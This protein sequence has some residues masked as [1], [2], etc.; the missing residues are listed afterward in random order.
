MDRD[1]RLQAES[2]LARISRDEWNDLFSDTE[3]GADLYLR[4]EAVR[5]ALGGAG[6]LPLGAKR[7]PVQELLDLRGDQLLNNDDLGPWIR[8]RLLRTMPETKWA[9]LVE[10][11]VEHS[12]SRA[13]RFHRNMVQHR[14]GPR[15][16]AG[17]WHH[18]GRWAQ[19]FCD[20]TG[21]PIDLAKRRTGSL[22]EDEDIL[23]AEPL[24]PLHDFQVE[25]YRSMRRLLRG[26][27]GSAAMLSLPTGA[28]KTRVAVEAICDHLAQENVGSRNVV[29]WI[30]MSNELQQQA[31]EC[32]RQVWQVP[33]H[34]D[35][36]GIRRPL[37][38]RLVRLWGG[39]SGDDIE[40][41]EQ[42]T[43]LIAG[44]DQLAAWARN[45]PDVLER[46]PRRRLACA[47]IDEA[48][49][50]V[51]REYRMVLNELGLRA[52]QRQ[53]RTLSDAPPVFGLSA[54]PWRSRDDESR[55]LRRYFK[56]N[57]VRPESLGSKP[58]KALQKRGILARVEHE[59]LLVR[60]TEPMTNA[61]RRR[62]EQFKDLPAD[63]LKQLGLSQARNAKILRRLAR[64]PKKRR[65]IVFACSVVHAEIVTVA[66]NQ[67]LGAG[68]AAVVTGQTPR[69]ERADVIERFRSGQLRFLC[70]V[71][72]LTTGFDAPRADVV[73]LTRPT[74][75]AV[76]YE[77]M[78]GR[79]LRGPRNG[80]TTRCLVID[81]QDD[82]MPEGILSYARVLE[83]WDR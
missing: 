2:V 7:K 25:V 52:K 43:A 22:P 60:D 14:S 75:S 81:V 4:L 23:P 45:R 39:R 53:W 34:R 20:V 19:A 64:L 42:P 74:T 70:N 59:R 47:L 17:Y 57:L 24:P 65:T 61:Q 13:D 49:G 67:A 68:S 21:L 83:L 54:T 71:G 29:I 36:H 6:L 10:H 78:V 82:G 5:D 51:T 32:F 8:E 31:W 77:Q 40:L 66:L 38:L 9:K 44:V 15:V 58:I 72:V 62:F 26:G 55:T 76:F 18:G 41:D 33:P 56:K 11:Y 48:H 50:V 73:C 3:F 30:S 79:G 1:A 69:S 37:P 27:H 63:Y 12:G 28:G 80:G 16:M 46:I 35:G